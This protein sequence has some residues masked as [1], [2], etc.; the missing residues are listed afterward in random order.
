MGSGTAVG[1]TVLAAVLVFPSAARPA[2]DP[3]IRQSIDR[4]VRFLKK[5]PVQEG[6]AHLAGYAA[7]KGLTLLE[8]GVPARDPAIRN[9]AGVV[10]PAALTLTHTYSL[11]L[12][13]LFLDRLGDPADVPLIQSMG[14]RL[15]AGQNMAGGW[16][17]DCPGVSPEETRR[18][19]V[20]PTQRKSPPAGTDSSRRPAE[21][22]KPVELP[23]EIQE[24]LKRIQPRPVAPLTARGP[25]PDDNSNTQFAI[26][27][28]WA[29]RRHGIPVEK[30]L[31]L[32]EGRFRG[33]QNADGGWAYQT[34]GPSRPTMT[35]AGLLALALS[36]GVAQE[37][38]ARADAGSLEQQQ[39]ARAAHDPGRDLAVRA[40]LQVLSTVVGQPSA[41]TQRPVQ[42]IPPGHAEFVYYFFWSL[43]RVAMVYDLKTIGHKDWY[44][45][46]AEIL[47]ASQN[48]AGAW[49]GQYGASV[50]TC[51][52]LLFLARANLAKDLT[53]ALKGRVE[54]PGE[55]A[56]R[57]GGVGGEKRVG[58]GL[59]LDLGPAPAANPKEPAPKAPATIPKPQPP[60]ENVP[61]LGQAARLTDELVR[62]PSDKQSPIIE[63]L[64]AGKG[65][66]HT[67]ALADAIPQLP[68]QARDK[69]RDALAERLMRMTAETLR[70]ELADDNLEVRCAAAR[71]CAGKGDPAHIPDLI[72]RLQDP[73]PRAARAAHTALKILSGGQD[74]GP[75]PDANA[76]DRA[77]AAAAWLKWW[78]ERPAEGQKKESG[79]P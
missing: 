1:S 43:E 71:A 31:V 46:G 13:I 17:Y 74:F 41:Q 40:G 61:E 2:D 79:K 36:H 42:V 76:A 72:A 34:S 45:W 73:E 15:L 57:A 10:R 30:A 78:K 55:V 20:L 66:V 8:C 67:Q 3:L 6:G 5:T 50:D 24:Q 23:P 26:L 11:A 12:A 60:K 62:A 51:F 63:R 27:A 29:A 38:A 47:V 32:A 9:L 28:L 48:R 44:A 33:T 56:L 4:G 16:T 14:V 65:A 19:R 35:C 75:A 39:R 37:A 25:L 64:K 70:Q 58:P 53:A 22:G 7:L 59:K 49:V 18:L 69:A 21:P 77:R 68:P 54:D 52:A